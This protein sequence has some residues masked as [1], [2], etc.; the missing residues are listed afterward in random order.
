MSNQS[1]K[2]A[3]IRAVT[4]TALTYE[5]DWQALFDLNSI[6]GENFNGRLLAYIN[7]KLSTSYTD[8]NSA[9]AALA[10]ANSVGS[11][12]QLGTF[13]AL[14]FSP[15]SISGLALWFDANDTATITQ[16]GGL[17]SQW[18]DKSANVYHATATTT[19]RPTT[20]TRTQFGRNALDFDGTAN[21]M[22]LPA[23]AYAI[24]NGP[25][26]VFCVY[27]QDTTA[28]QQR[29]FYGTAG[30]PR[31]GFDLLTTPAITFAS[32][33][34]NA[35]AA[36]VSATHDTSVHIATGRRSG[37]TQTVIRDGV[38]PTTN[39]NAVSSA[40][41][42]INIGSTPPTGTFFDGLICEVIAY[43]SSLSDAN[44]NLVG[45]YLKQ[46]WGGTWTNL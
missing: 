43:N 13:D 34:S 24:P 22:A 5:G 12:D 17:V 39:A 4:G 7:L 20:G 33:S 11:W 21:T 42:G 1:S 27:R 45:N 37:T 16:S 23:G 29:P 28:T 10:G 8:V 32:G 31:W 38:S 9:M 41:T 19:A 15:P 30:T 14:V 40:M 3:S 36:S 35:L 44:V 26:T 6:A 46:K 2:Q 18:N 25:N